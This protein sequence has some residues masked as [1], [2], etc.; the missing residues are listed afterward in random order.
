MWFRLTGI[1][2][3]CCKVIVVEDY[4][5]YMALQACSESCLNYLER[6]WTL[7]NRQKNV[8]KTF[9]VKANL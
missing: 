2:I 1:Y 6:Q 5:K 4:R 3:Q 7:F 9:N 8:A